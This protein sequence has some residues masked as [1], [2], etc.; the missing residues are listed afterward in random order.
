MYGKPSL[1]PV[2]EITLL[3]ADTWAS[4]RSQHW[5]SLAAWIASPPAM[6]GVPQGYQCPVE[7]ALP[8][9][10]C[11]GRVLRCCILTKIATTSPVHLLGSEN[12]I[13][14]RR[15]RD[16]EAALELKSASWCC[17]YQ[18]ACKDCMEIYSKISNWGEQSTPRVGETLTALIASERDPEQRRSAQSCSIEA[19]DFV[20]LQKKVF[21]FQSYS[22]VLKGLH[23]ADMQQ[24]FHHIG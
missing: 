11:T 23:C 8:K 4:F 2:R 6:C 12:D 15:A 7:A 5:Q 14:A 1:C 13:W 19:A 16:P 10:I 22:K 24:T 20:T 3:P 17:N 18:A 9:Y 21:C